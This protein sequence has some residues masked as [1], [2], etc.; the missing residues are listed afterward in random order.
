MRFL[1]I[2]RS[3]QPSVNPLPSPRAPAVAR[4]EAG[5]VE[6]SDTMHIPTSTW[7]QPAAGNQTEVQPH[8]SESKGS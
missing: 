2:E 1:C 4:S 7:G 8:M 5:P 6:R 3:V